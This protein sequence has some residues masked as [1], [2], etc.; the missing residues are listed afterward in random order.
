[1]PKLEYFLVA[2]SYSSDK[3]VDAISIFNVFN[4][5]RFKKLPETVPKLVTISCWLSSQ[6]EIAEHSDHQV[7]IRFSLPGESE[8]EYRGNFQCDTKCQHVVLEL[9]NV[10]ISRSGEITVALSIDEEY[11]CSHTIF[12]SVEGD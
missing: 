10:K 11:K 7:V 4:Q 2:E 3:D 9:Q 5:F 6:E 1:M 8:R 12:V